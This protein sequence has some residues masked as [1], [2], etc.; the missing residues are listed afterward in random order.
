MGKSSQTSFLNIYKYNCSPGHTKK[1]K[2]ETIF[3]ATN[4]NESTMA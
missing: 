4:F 1:E 2:T 3:I